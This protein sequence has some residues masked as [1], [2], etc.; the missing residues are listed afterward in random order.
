MR[1]DAS[2]RPSALA[3]LRR[4]ASLRE[5]SR[6]SRAPPL[7]R[8]ATAFT[9]SRWSFAAALG[10]AWAVRR[11]LLRAFS[12]WEQAAA[13]ASAAAYTRLTR[14][15]LR[16]WRARARAPLRR[17][18]EARGR[19]AGWLARASSSEAAL[20]RAASGGGGAGA[21]ARVALRRCVRVW[22][23][24]MAVR[25]YHR[26]VHEGC[27]RL[28]RLT[29]LREASEA[30]RRR[31]AD[32]AA[33][34]ARR[35]G[36]WARARAA[37]HLARS[38]S[39]RALR[40]LH[41]RVG[42][43]RA[44]R[45]ARL[46]LRRWAARSGTR[47]GWAAMA[48]A[49]L[50]AERARLVR[51]A[52]EAHARHGGV[53]RAVRR[54]Y[55][56]MRCAAE[57]RRLLRAYGRAA[58][59]LYDDA[60]RRGVG[61][62]WRLW[63]AQASEL[64][65]R[66]LQVV[67]TALRR[68]GVESPAGATADWP[69][70]MRRREAWLRWASWR[71]A[72]LVERLRARRVRAG[73]ERRAVSGAVQSLHLAARRKLRADTADAAAAPRGFAA[74]AAR[75]LDAWVRGARRAAARRAAGE[76]AA[77]K[78]RERWAASVEAWGEWR[79]WRAHARASQRHVR[80]WSGWRRLCAAC[81]RTATLA[82]SLIATRRSTRWRY[83]RRGWDLFR[84][85]CSRESLL[86]TS[87]N[88]ATRSTRWRY[89]QRG[90]DSFGTACARR[91]RLATGL[92]ATTRSTRW[93]YL[94]R[95]W[96]DFSTACARKSM[97]TAS[98]IATTRSTRWRHLRQGWGI[99]A[100]ACARTSTLATSR[101]STTHSTR[102][103]YL[104]RGWEIFTTVCARE[105]MLATSLNS[106]T[107]SARWRLLRRG[108]DTLFA[109]CATRE[110][111]AALLHSGA[112]LLHREPWRHRGLVA[113]RLDEQRG[114]PAERVWAG[115][116]SPVRTAPPRTPSTA[117]ALP[118]HH[119]LTL[120]LPPHNS[121][122]PPSHEAAPRPPP[123]LPLP[124]APASAWSALRVE[125]WT[126]TDRRKSLELARVH[127]FYYACAAAF[128]QWLRASSG[129]LLSRVWHS[130]AA[131]FADVHRIRRA[132]QSLQ[133]RAIERA[134]TRFSLSAAEASWGGVARASAMA[135]WRARAAASAAAA[136][137]LEAEATRRRAACAWR[138]WRFSSARLPVV[139]CRAPQLRQI[140][141]RLSRR[142]LARGWA[143][144]LAS[145]AHCR[146]SAS[147]RRAAA[148]AH[149]LG[150]AWRRLL[151]G[152]AAARAAGEMRRR[153]RR[154]AWR[155]L[156]AAC[157][158]A[159]RERRAVAAAAFARRAAAA[160]AWRRLAAARLFWRRAARARGAVTLRLLRSGWARL[161]EAAV[162]SYLLA[163]GELTVRRA[164]VRLVE[165]QVGVL[166]AAAT[167]RRARAFHWYEAC[168][169]ALLA[170]Q[171]A[172]AGRG[173]TRRGVAQ[174]A[175]L[176][177]RRRCRLAVARWAGASA[178]RAQLRR[179]APLVDAMARASLLR[180]LRRPWRVLTRL[181]Q[182]AR[183]ASLRAARRRKALHGGLRLWWLGAARGALRAAQRL[184]SEDFHATRDARRALRTLHSSATRRM[185]ALAV[186]IHWRRRWLV[187]SFGEWSGKAD[188]RRVF[189]KIYRRRE[190]SR[191]RRCLVRW[192]LGAG[193]AAR[194]AEW[195]RASVSTAAR[196]VLRHAWRGLVG[197]QRK[198]RHA[199]LR[200]ARRSKLVLAKHLALWSAAW[201][202][203]RRASALLVRA[204]SDA[205]RFRARRARLSFRTWGN[206]S[207][208]WSRVV[209]RR[210]ERSV[211][212]RKTALADWLA[213]A[214]Q[215]ASLEGVAQ[216]LAREQR[217][218][219]L[220]GCWKRWQLATSNELQ[221]AHA[222]RV[223]RLHVCL[224]VWASWSYAE[225]RVRVASRA[226]S[227]I[228]TRRG[229]KAW[230][231]ACG[232][233]VALRSWNARSRQRGRSRLLRSRVR[234]WRVCALE[235]VGARQKR[236]RAHS[237]WANRQKDI[238]CTGEAMQPC[239]LNVAYARND[240]LLT[241]FCS[242]RSCAPPQARRNRLAHAWRGWV[243]RAR[244]TG[245]LV[246]LTSTG[247]HAASSGTCRYW[248]QR[249]ELLGH[250]IVASLLLRRWRRRT[251]GGERWR[252]VSSPLEE[253]W[254]SAWRVLV[255]ERQV[256]AAWASWVVHTERARRGELRSQLDAARSMT[257]ALQ[258]QVGG[259]QRWR[260]E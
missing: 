80:L 179:V 27:A 64:T 259:F 145:D 185:I 44:A 175:A 70:L 244:V 78:A 207:Q 144:W 172:S 199:Q 192:L 87:L 133:S 236:V 60:R 235:R 23:C 99:F 219:L 170:W 171:L 3:T 122:P 161:G 130:W 105:S 39:A 127:A 30:W 153:R 257:D 135:A 196:N 234:A 152:A 121:R 10:G 149:A 4:G 147:A 32:A 61:G 155:R 198:Q 183:E 226:T 225:A 120:A 197:A 256:A 176:L 218:Y 24:R 162:R 221:T 7:R 88:S 47:R 128:G 216:R 51:V 131:D 160:R 174:A 251:L 112:N 187:T 48:R 217:W 9:P 14:R 227:S 5:M 40:R 20:L 100:S 146:P 204:M 173:A 111:S 15:A 59:V 91:S 205:E 125:S 164:W 189:C 104:Q 95:G 150:V 233:V 213:R 156:R 143:R 38:A 166:H 243:G 211:R 16:H 209:R 246:R 224:R 93:R 97:L 57:R 106:S 142:R 21:R 85:A 71:D 1:F 182:A 203:R 107:R 222:V 239:S 255:R 212:L 123:P 184:Q 118:G 247:L 159:P 81:A 94:R 138:R 109:R 41:A 31:G 67:R 25:A 210:S 241:F 181:L 73:I 245:L 54:A 178:R 220:L 89:L 201:S 126:R 45:E 258:D 167:T 165:H 66:R 36:V 102:W 136:L 6:L 117:R 79:G 77:R 254:H 177:R 29:R 134:A 194:A 65:R 129:R 250:G 242:R 132:L 98:V 63:A 168:A 206:A 191:V 228:L 230:V 151:R 96:D 42:A 18:R 252:R 139:A 11:S 13:A 148:V 35:F 50:R 115:E 157:R 86:A 114:A 43:A 188:F 46:R 90:W 229:L 19:S 208:G 200:E 72:R 12:A 53:R 238:D 34:A 137:S 33:A 237:W 37:A 28:L 22:C 248:W 69:R 116:R 169:R 103:R 108:W 55:V 231:N 140:A 180:R 154:V 193:Q 214:R 240:C 8:T 82:T 195:T 186:T 2:R 62:A 141:R 75:G 190:R 202:S 68:R 83:L 17:A 56:R 49:R 163:L 215:Q 124:P 58:A 101:N 76:M 253:A 110:T 113:T 52:A 26:E 74:A 92:I 232:R 260:V 84:T 119:A 223:L 158:R 249:A